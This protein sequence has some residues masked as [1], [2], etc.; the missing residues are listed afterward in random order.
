MASQLRP[1]NH[2]GRS[3]GRLSSAPPFRIMEIS[4]VDF[5]SFWPDAQCEHNRFCLVGFRAAVQ[6]TRR[7]TRQRKSVGRPTGLFGS[8]PAPGQWP[9]TISKLQLSACE[10]AQPNRA[11][12]AER[13]SDRSTAIAP[14]V[15]ASPRRP[16][17]SWSPR[18]CGFSVHTIDLEYDDQFDRSRRHRQRHGV[19]DDL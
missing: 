9:G 7:R 2:E 6:A 15:P 8:Q 19:A 13:R 11:G 16:P 1:V 12:L 5:R 10:G 18:R 17:S 4:L 3:S 14:V